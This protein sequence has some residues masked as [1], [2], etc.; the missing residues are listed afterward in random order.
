MRFIQAF[1][2]L[3]VVS[4]LLSGCAPVFSD[5]QSAKLVGKG[6]YEITP[7]VSEVDYSNNGESR[8]IQSHIGLQAAYGL[9]DD[10]DIRIRYERI[11]VGVNGSEDWAWN[12]IG[13]GPKIELT[14][15]VSAFYLPVGFAYGDNITDWSE[16]WEIHPTFLFTIPLAD[17]IELNPSAKALIPLSTN[18][19]DILFAINLG[20]GLSSNYDKWVIRPELGFLLNPRSDDYYRHFSIGLTLYP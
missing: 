10:T 9:R 3:A 7:S 11:S 1:G 12:V 5:L 16:T 17:N 8:E 20:A 2:L 6:E 4:F 19:H 14:K 13:L 15:D 18:N